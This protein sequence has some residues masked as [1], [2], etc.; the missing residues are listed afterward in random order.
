MRF[1]SR[2]CT[3][4]FRVFVSEVVNGREYTNGSGFLFAGLVRREGGDRPLHFLIRI[5]WVSFP[6]GSVCRERFSHFAL[7]DLIGYIHLG[8]NEDEHASE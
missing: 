6:P 3:T 2:Y 8:E 1:Y 5:H 7:S 4:K